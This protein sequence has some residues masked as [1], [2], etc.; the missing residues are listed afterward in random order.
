MSDSCS[1]RALAS[2]SNL[3]LSSGGTAWKKR[4]RLSSSTAVPFSAP[5]SS[6]RRCLVSLSPP[7]QRN[8]SNPA[9]VSL[10]NCKPLLAFC[11]ASRTGCFLAAIPS[12]P[13]TP[14]TNPYR[15]APSVTLPLLAPASRPGPGD[16]DL[17][18]VHAVF[19]RGGDLL[20]DG[21]EELVAGQ[22]LD[23]AD[24]HPVLAPVEV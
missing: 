10:V 11:S 24:G 1:W 8:G 3:A 21:R 17:H 18:L 5:A 12:P 7:S 13:V 14:E 22:L 6:S 16:P 19:E 2:L 15:I 20:G 9:S 23:P 4:S